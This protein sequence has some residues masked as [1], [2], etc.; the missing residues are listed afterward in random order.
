MNPVTHSLLEK[1]NNPVLADFVAHWDAFE[2]LIIFVFRAGKSSRPSRA[3]HRRL[4]ATLQ[5]AYPAWQP[6]LSSHWPLVKINGESI[7]S[8]P[9]LSLL[10]VERAEQF[11]GNW[12]AMQTLPAAREALNLLLIAMIE[13]K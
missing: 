7:A 3:E 2:E 1:L 9:F 11:V 12:A 6:S 8:D 5:S 4:R 10:A 13:A